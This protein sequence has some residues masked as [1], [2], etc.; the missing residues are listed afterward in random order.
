MVNSTFANENRTAVNV[1]SSPS[2]AYKGPIEDNKA[3]TGVQRTR[4]DQIMGSKAT[5]PFELYQQA[6]QLYVERIL[7]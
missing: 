5:Q 7:N 4:T 1:G 6:P 2:G 3:Q